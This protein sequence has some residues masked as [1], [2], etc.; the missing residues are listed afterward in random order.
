MALAS[1]ATTIHCDPN[2]SA[3]SFTKL[4]FSTA[5]VFMLTLSAPDLKSF[6]ISSIFLTPPPTVR[7]IKT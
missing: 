1:T 4:G 3:A 6:L 2:L 7:G 5:E